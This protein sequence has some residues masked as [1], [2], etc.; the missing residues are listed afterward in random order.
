MDQKICLTIKPISHSTPKEE[1]L[2]LEWFQKIPSVTDVA[3]QDGNIHIFFADKEVPEDDLHDL[4][5]VFYRFNIDIKQL[6]L[7]LDS[8]EKDWQFRQD[9]NPNHHNMWPGGDK[10]PAFIKN[11]IVCGKIDYFSYLDEDLFFIWLRSIPSVI[12][13]EGIREKLYLH[14]PKGNIT[15]E[16][17]AELMRLFELYKVDTKQ[18]KKLQSQTRSC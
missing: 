16:D 9:G 15:E 6:N 17:F 13:H 2:F 5:A 14:I 7:F 11:A 1:K 3:Q 12:E 8:I 4:S 10:K 18:L